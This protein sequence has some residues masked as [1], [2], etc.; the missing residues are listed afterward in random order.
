MRLKFARNEPSRLH[1]GKLSFARSG[2]NSHQKCLSI[3]FLMFDVVRRDGEDKKMN[4]FV[5]HGCWTQTCGDEGAADSHTGGVC[6]PGGCSGLPTGASCAHVAIAQLATSR[7]GCE[8]RLPVPL[9]HAV[10]CVSLLCATPG[11]TLL[12]QSFEH[13]RGARVQ[14][15]RWAVP[16]SARRERR[17]CVQNTGTPEGAG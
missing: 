11:G 10:F 13:I 6:V 12:E 14:G 5:A 1:R 7:W 8:T 17:T 4:K 9:Q 16:A 2:E 3:S 15:C